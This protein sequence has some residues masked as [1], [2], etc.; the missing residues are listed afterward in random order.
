MVPRP[1]CSMRSPHH[2]EGQRSSSRIP[3]SAQGRTIFPVK[4]H[5]ESTGFIAAQV[6]FVV[7]GIS[8]SELDDTPISSGF[9]VSK[10]A[11]MNFVPIKGAGWMP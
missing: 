10:S 8:C 7:H 5:N 3:A 2:A 11:P 9:D 4:S 1:H 6:S